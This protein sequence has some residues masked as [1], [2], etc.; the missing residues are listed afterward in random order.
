M[1]KHRKKMLMAATA[2]VV[3]LAVNGAAHAHDPDPQLPGAPVLETL[4]G[5][6]AA[7][8]AIDFDQHFCEKNEK[9]S[10]A[11]EDELQ[12][13]MEEAADVYRQHADMKAT[14]EKIVTEGYGGDASQFAGSDYLKA[15]EDKYLDI[16]QIHD[17]IHMGMRDDMTGPCSSPDEHA[18]ETAAYEPGD[19][20][21]DEYSEG[22]EEVSEFEQDVAFLLDA[23]VL[24]ASY[25]EVRV[26]GLPREFCSEE[27]RDSLS[28][29]IFELEKEVTSNI[30][31]AMKLYDRAVEVKYENLDSVSSYPADHP[32][33]REALMRVEV[34]IAGAQADIEY[35]RSVRTQLISLSVALDTVPIVDCDKS[36]MEDH[37]SVPLQEDGPAQNALVRPQPSLDD[38][39]N[40][41]HVAPGAQQAAAVIL[42]Q[43]NLDE[44]AGL[45]AMAAANQSI[46]RVREIQHR[47]EEQSAEDSQRVS[48]QTGGRK[49]QSQVTKKDSGKRSDAAV[50]AGQKRTGVMASLYKGSS[51]KNA[52]SY[53]AKTIIDRVGVDAAPTG[54]S[55]AAFKIAPVQ[56]SAPNKTAKGRVTADFSPLA[57]AVPKRT[58]VQPG[59]TTAGVKKVEV[60]NTIKKTRPTF[61]ATFP[62]AGPTAPK[63]VPGQ[64]TAVKAPPLVVNDYLGNPIKDGQR[65]GQSAVLSSTVQ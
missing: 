62:V 16:M 20:L 54:K 2:M 38:L 6:E 5:I 32:V 26:P 8:L 53:P 52:K 9:T 37:G 17:E 40:A 55:H 34:V 30:R 29:R 11:L 23:F 50:V 27:E 25:T 44:F 12:D 4:K 14:L 21:T 47:L 33:H 13:L 51:K 39:R 42:P 1:F 10:A 57:V 65:T 7:I 58:P 49:A 41:M 28:R 46:V 59:K 48:N 3:G 35:W 31:E 24:E 18:A 64:M 60:P 22:A 19:P 63:K 36:A 43:D 15:F 61:T 45:D 56:K